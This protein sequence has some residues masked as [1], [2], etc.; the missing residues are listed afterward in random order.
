MKRTSLGNATTNHNTG[1]GEAFSC[2]CVA[3][4][5]TMMMLVLALVGKVQCFEEKYCLHL[6]D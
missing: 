5:M 6:Q 4:M 2:R 1:L 3:V